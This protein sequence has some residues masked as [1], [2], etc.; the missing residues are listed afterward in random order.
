MLCQASFGQRGPTGW[1]R[2]H[3]A[4]KSR[5]SSRLGNPF[6]FSVVLLESHPSLAADASSSACVTRHENDRPGVVVVVVGLGGWALP[7]GHSP[8]KCP[9][10]LDSSLSVAADTCGHHKDTNTSPWWW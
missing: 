10:S 5:K 4:K 9:S 7:T 3:A 8:A 2:K 1:E 6:S